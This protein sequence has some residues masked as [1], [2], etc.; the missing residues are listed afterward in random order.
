MKRVTRISRSIFGGILFSL[1][2]FHI[3]DGAA[4][5]EIVHL[6]TLDQLHVESVAQQNF[7]YNFIALQAF[8]ITNVT[9]ALSSSHT[10]SLADISSMSVRINHSTFS[11]A[12]YNA[13]DGTISFTGDVNIANGS[14]PHLAI[15]CSCDADAVHLATVRGA[16]WA[17][18]AGV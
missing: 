6:D 7:S 5:A 15:N 13:A 14:V 9:L 12:G 11:Y 3:A 4:R 16:E 10:P 18:G 2:L 17:S 1:S 8:R